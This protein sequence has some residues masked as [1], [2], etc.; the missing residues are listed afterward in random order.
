MRLA[1]SSARPPSGGRCT[2][3]CQRGFTLVEL[4]MVMMLV[5]VITAMSAARFS[6]R[7]PFAVQGAA[8]Q[9]VSGL[10]LAQATAIAQR[11][12]IHVSL[13]GNPAT[14]RTDHWRCRFPAVADGIDGTDISR[15][16][17]RIAEAG[18]DA[19]K[20]ENLYAFDG[21]RGYSQAQG[22]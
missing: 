12:P 7:E 6:D 17:M 19:V 2:P 20:T 21:D 1:R 15:L 22:E 10:R 14:L 3:A 4:V 11:R 9:L 18:F 13:T 8:D 5:A 16:L